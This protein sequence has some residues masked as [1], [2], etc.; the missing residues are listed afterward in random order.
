MANL[1]TGLYDTETAA[2]AGVS[3]LKNMGY[4][5][6]EITIIMKDRGSA[7]TLAHETGSRTMEGVGTGATIGGTIGAVLA[8]LLAVGT[9]TIPGVGLVAAGS[10]AAVLA[11]AGAG[12][13][14]GG[15]IGWLASAGVPDEVAPYYERGL[16]TGGVVVAVAA[17][18]GDETRVQQ[19][20]QSGAVAYAGQN[21]T[22]YV[23]PEYRS[24][25][26]DIGNGVPGIQTGGRDADGTPDTRGVSEKV[27]DAVTGD[28]I[29]DKTG[30]PVM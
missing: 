25:H 23:S 21:T 8:A 20:L 12:G 26:A 5:Q 16:Q 17:H 1:I 19:A 28:R 14:A 4:G 13:V 10:L 6:N 11:G 9:V 2:E 29:D 22:S 7:D 27:A 24:R 3:Q 30:K 15:L 18:P